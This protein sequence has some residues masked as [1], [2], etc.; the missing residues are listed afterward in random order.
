MPDI[1][2]HKF[3]LSGKKYDMIPQERSERWSSVEPRHQSGYL[4]NNTML[5]F[6]K[7]KDDVLKRVLNEINGRIKELGIY[8]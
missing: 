1:S 3:R 5:L 7:K 6:S 2:S 8:E 4:T